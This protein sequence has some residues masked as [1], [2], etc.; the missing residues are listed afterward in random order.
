MNNLTIN[1]L[2]HLKKFYKID[3]QNK[4]KY[5]KNKYFYFQFKLNLYEKV[6]DKNKNKNVTLQINILC[7][8]LLLLAQLGTV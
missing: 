5:F 2:Y 7:T 4:L 8:D 3:Q 1:T 6:H